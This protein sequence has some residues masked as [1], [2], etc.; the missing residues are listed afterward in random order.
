MKEKNETT[1]LLIWN[2]PKDLKAQF[3]AVCAKKKIS[4]DLRK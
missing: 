3:K 1:Q 4:M 2:I